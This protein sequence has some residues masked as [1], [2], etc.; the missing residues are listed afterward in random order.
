MDNYG[1]VFDS[2]PEY[3][4][5]FKLVKDAGYVYLCRRGTVTAEDVSDENLVS[6]SQAKRLLT[7]F[8]RFKEIVLD[9]SGVEIIGQAFA[10]ELFRAF[11]ADHPSTHLTYLNANEQVEKMILR[12]SGPSGWLST[13]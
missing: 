11:Q 5:T 13:T 7:R 12:A 1:A 10:D 4:L 2:N 9:F 6:R 3:P 8:D